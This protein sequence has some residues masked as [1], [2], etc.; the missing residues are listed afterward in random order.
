MTR[1]KDYQ[2]SLNLN[3]D[4]IRQGQPPRV[5]QVQQI[6]LLKYGRN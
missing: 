5:T 4:H 6:V 2:E 3:L 1:F